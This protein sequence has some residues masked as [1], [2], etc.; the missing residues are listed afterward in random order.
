M[1][2]TTATIVMSWPKLLLSWVT[3]FPI[4]HNTATTP[5]RT[6]VSARARS[7]DGELTYLWLALWVGIVSGLYFVLRYRGHWGEVDSAIFTQ[8]VG[9]LPDW[10]RIKYP[11]S[12]SH[13]YAYSVWAASLSM[14]W[15]VEVA[16]LQ[17]WVTP[18]VGNVFL[19]LFGYVAFKR[20][21]GSYNWVC[22]QLP[23]CFWCR[24]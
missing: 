23:H 20:W 13:G 7:R 17:R 16:Q 14:V 4:G 22:W 2:Q 10:N 21:L 9:S 1:R 19:A 3:G 5:Q 8:M 11:N 12:Y 24:N 15:Q 6:Q 18:L